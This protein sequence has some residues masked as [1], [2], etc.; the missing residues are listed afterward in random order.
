[1]S[2]ARS[3]SPDV[4]RYRDYGRHE[5]KPYERDDRR[6]RRTWQ[7]NRDGRRRGDDDDRRHRND[8]DHNESSSKSNSRRSGNRDTLRDGSPSRPSY[9]PVHDPDDDRDSAAASPQS[10]R[11]R[12]GNIQDSRHGTSNDAPTPG[13]TG[14]GAYGDGEEQD[15]AQIAAMM[16]FG[17]FGTTKGQKV[18]GNVKG[19]VAKVAKRIEYRQYMNRP[20][21]FNRELSP[22]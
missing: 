5:R 19:S 9:R 20:G 13:G 14:D 1:M 7:D 12:P 8:S 10:S 2:R 3:R 16:G 18:S 15:E 6:E 17:G 21:G 4:R 11:V 22:A